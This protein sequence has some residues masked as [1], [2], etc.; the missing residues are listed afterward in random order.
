MIVITMVLAKV[1]ELINP[2]ARNPTNLQNPN[3]HRTPFA[4]KTPYPEKFYTQGL[5]LE[6]HIIVAN[7]LALNPQP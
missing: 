7:A 3:P 5:K 4:A 1:P 2:S 6:G